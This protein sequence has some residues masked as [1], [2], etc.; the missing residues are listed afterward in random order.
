MF[1]V[2]KD[3]FLKTFRIKKEYLKYVEIIKLDSLR[4]KIII[5]E[6]FSSSAFYN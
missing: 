5:K 1:Y 2:E 4:M 6:I 3:V